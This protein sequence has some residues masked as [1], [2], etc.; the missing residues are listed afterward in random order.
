VDI[1]WYKHY[2]EHKKLRYSKEEF[3]KNLELDAPFV[4]LLKRYLPAGGR[5]LEAGCGPARTA[6]SVAHAGYSVTA[7]DKD[8]R[9]LA[10]ARQ[11]AAIAG[12]HMEFL[13]GDLEALDESDGKYDCVTHQGVLEHFGRDRVPVL[14]SGQLQV[15]LFV[16]F[17]VPVNSE[18]NATYFSDRNHRNLWTDEEWLELLNGFDIIEY[19]LVRQRSDNLLLALRRS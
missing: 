18:F 10:M 17:S 11:N 6:I 14:L 1:D 19:R 13:R 8:P 15:A 5:I 4:D 9:M 12:V 3:L 2:I 16:I 7:M